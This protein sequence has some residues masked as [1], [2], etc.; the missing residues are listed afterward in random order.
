MNP[1]TLLVILACTLVATPACDPDVDGGPAPIEGESPAHGDCLDGAAVTGFATCVDAFAPESPASFGHDAMPGI[2]LGPPRPAASGGSTDV[3]SLGCGGSITLGVAGGIDDRPG[4]DF[5][6]FEN[7]FVA[8]DIT[9]VE[10]ATVLVSDDGEQWFEFPCDAAAPEPEGCA[11]V[12]PTS[13][14]P[15]DGLRDATRAGGD[16]FDLEALG[17]THV[18][19]IRL[20]DRTRE[21]YGDD[22]W[23]G[24]GGGGFDLDAIAEVAS[25]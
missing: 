23:C 15:R 8:G 22:M 17:L 20:R 14:A 16:G 1:C 3:A 25:P 13:N 5:L 7:P 4:I 11:G 21:H 2:V 9:F 18:E 6:V 12:T 19:W 24:G 10:P